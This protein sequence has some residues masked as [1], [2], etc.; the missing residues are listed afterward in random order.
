M[1]ESVISLG[2]YLVDRLFD[3]GE[4]QSDLSKSLSKRWTDYPSGAPA[5]VAAAVAKLGISTRMI[6]CLGQDELGDW[7]IQVLHGQGRRPNLERLEGD[8]V[9]AL[10]ASLKRH[11]VSDEILQEALGK[12]TER[13]PQRCVLVELPNIILQERTE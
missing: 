11:G 6:S 9:S 10:L 8:S 5:N 1:T 2:E 3:V 7:L 4:Q 12:G 13:Q